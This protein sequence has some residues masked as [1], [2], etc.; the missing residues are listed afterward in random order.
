MLPSNGLAIVLMFSF[1]FCFLYDLKAQNKV[2]DLSCGTLV[3]LSGD[4]LAFK[5]VERTDFYITGFKQNK[6]TKKWVVKTYA[7][8]DILYYQN[9]NEKFY[10]Y[11]YKPS[12]GSFL[13]REEMEQYTLG[14]KDAI[15]GYF[16]K[17]KFLKAALFGV[18]LG[19]F[20]TSFDFYERG[21]GFLLPPSYMG[22]LNSNP[23]FLSISAPLIST[24]L[25]EKN[26]L[27]L[28]DKSIMNEKTILE[29][30]YTHGYENVKTAKDTKAVARG[31]LAGICLIIGLTFL[32]N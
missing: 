18:L 8:S 24:T 30:S 21:K 25:V 9:D 16:P 1:S 7:S 28:I 5:E 29:E 12:H 10:F 23:S 11:K 19:V 31:S 22:V 27:N 13:S 14:Q 3:F 2:D 20:D 6:L 32:K 26:K 15:Y 4:T 17:N